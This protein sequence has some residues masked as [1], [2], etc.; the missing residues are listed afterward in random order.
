MYSPTHEEWASRPLSTKKG[1]TGHRS[2]PHVIAP[3]VPGCIAEEVARLLTPADFG[4][5]AMAGVFIA[6]GHKPNTDMFADQLEMEGGYIQI[7][8]GIEGNATGT[9]VAGVFAA[10]DVADH[11]YHQAVTS[12][13]AWSSVRS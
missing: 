2:A 8:S 1:R 3:G 11:V 12:A 10:G 4:L 13:G 9:S 5:V 6:I 7:Q